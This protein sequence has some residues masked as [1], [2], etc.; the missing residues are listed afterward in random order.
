MINTHF[1]HQCDWKVTLNIVGVMVWSRDTAW[2]CK[3]DTCMLYIEHT[4]T[5]TNVPSGHMDSEKKIQGQ[6]TGKS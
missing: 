6:D 2:K 4:C 1:Q 5:Y 3:Q